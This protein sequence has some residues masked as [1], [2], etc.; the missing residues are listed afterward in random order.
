MHQTDERISL[1]DLETLTA[2]YR[3]FLDRFFG[4]R[5]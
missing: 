3:E 1:A 2:V 4:Q 5:R